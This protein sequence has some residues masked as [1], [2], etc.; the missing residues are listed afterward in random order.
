MYDRFVADHRY[1][2]ARQARSGLGLESIF[3]TTWCLAIAA[4]AVLHG[5]GVARASIVYDAN[6]SFVA[7]E[8][9]GGDTNPFGPFSAGHSPTVGGFTAFTAAE[10][11]N[12][13]A[14]DPDL[15][16]WFVNTDAIVPAAVV[17]TSS[18]PTNTFFSVTVDP[19]QILMHPGG[20]SGTGFVPPI[21][22]AILRFTAPT[23]GLY[24]VAGDWEKLHSGTTMDSILKN[25]LSLFS[26]TAG[27]TPF[28]LSVSLAIGD[29]IDFVVNDYD[30][31]G[32][33]STGLRAVLTNHSVPEPSS[34]ILL[35][36]G[37]F[38][39]ARGVH[40]RRQT[41]PAV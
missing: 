10:H 1:S 21:H 9:G 28:S 26:T 39:L 20:V 37:L 7:N 15:Q 32:S 27:N 14:G 16:G 22:D 31:I 17:N 29:T 33:D 11:T 8:T 40:R 19:G 34:L 5:I 24:S 2:T 36:L 4:L 38:G 12:S 23:A 13:W 30:G 35:G 6:A 41:Q 18:S 3:R 25:G